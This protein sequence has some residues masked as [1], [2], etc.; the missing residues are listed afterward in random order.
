MKL[1][2]ET[3][4]SIGFAIFILLIT[5]PISIQTHSSFYLLGIACIVTWTSL[6]YIRSTLPEEDDDRPK[7]EIVS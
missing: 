7:L 6:M 1:S 3:K 2:F 5:V 4:M